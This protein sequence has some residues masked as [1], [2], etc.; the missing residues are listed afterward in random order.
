MRHQNIVN[1]LNKRNREDVP[2]LFWLVVFVVAMLIM[3]PDSEAADAKLVID[4]LECESSGRYN[5]Y[6]KKDKGASYGIA[7]FRED[8]FYEFAKQAGMKKMRYKNPIH[9]LR[10]MNWALDNGY[11]YRWTCYRK[12]FPVMDS[13][14]AEK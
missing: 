10:V 12:M 2:P 5:V 13:V 9:Q 3:I 7:Q 11:G 6:G 4:L 8:T 1:R 14:R